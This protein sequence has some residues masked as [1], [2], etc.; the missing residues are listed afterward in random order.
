MGL[1]K[2]MKSDTVRPINIR[3]PLVKAFHM[4]IVKRNKSDLIAYLEHEQIVLSKVDFV[5]VR[6]DIKNAF[7]AI[8]RTAIIENLQEEP[9]LQPLTWFVA[10][11]QSSELGE[12]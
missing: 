3:N 12:L 1:F 4:Q 5:A 10:L 7:N 9:P 11:T 6:V 8:E 2:S